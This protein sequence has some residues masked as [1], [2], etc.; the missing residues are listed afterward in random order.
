MELSLIHIIFAFI[1]IMFF[2]FGA[3]LIFDLIYTEIRKRRRAQTR[4]KIIS[5]GDPAM[6]A[7][8][9]APWLFTGDLSLVSY[10]DTRRQESIQRATNE[11]ISR[12]I[13]PTTFIRVH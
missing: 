5:L 6:L 2:L 1:F 9:D 4:E 12:G 11:I 8:H 13:M 7:K 3:F 10:L